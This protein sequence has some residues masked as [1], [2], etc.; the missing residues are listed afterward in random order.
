MT[1]RLAV[2]LCLVGAVVAHAEDAK[3]RAAREELERELRQMVGT[4]PTKVRIEYVPVDEPNYGLEDASFELDGKALASPSLTELESDGTHLI[5][6]GD[7]SPGKHALKARLVF[8][9][10]TSAVL[11][12]EGGYKWKVGGDVSWE[13]QSGIEVRV[14][15][16]PSRDASQ[17]E[18]S[19]RF[20]LSLPAQ[21]VMLAKLED[22]K[23]P[24]A[25]RPV[26][27]PVVDAG[28]PALAVA[29]VLDAGTRIAVADAPPPQPPPEPLPEPA[30]PTATDRSRPSVPVAVSPRPAPSAPVLPTP[31]VTAVDTGDASVAE[32][33]APGPSVP[34]AEEEPA[35]WI[36][37][38]GGVALLAIV[39]VLLARRSG[40]PPRLDD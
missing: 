18:V 14:Q 31:E 13:Q 25:P 15:V 17:K 36:W 35:W 19:K 2:L 1:R 33:P 9:N 7:V 21:P 10:G 12:D 28:T 27:P 6:S 26:L 22:G 34:P 23:M 38:V 4:V 8:A 32:A 16:V 37:A 24:E 29:P 3:A 30:Q 11:S 20:K 39:F 40:R 5:W